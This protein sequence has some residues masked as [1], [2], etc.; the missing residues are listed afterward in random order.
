SELSRIVRR[1]CARVNRTGLFVRLAASTLEPARR[2]PVIAD[3]DARPV[4]PKDGDVF[5]TRAAFRV[6]TFDFD[7][8]HIR[9]R[10]TEKRPDT[11]RVERDAFV[12]APGNNNTF[13]ATVAG[14]RRE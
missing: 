13:Q 3:M 7:P 14:A 6:L 8:V 4:T 9:R 12:R 11:N 2:T 5:A 10:D 1:D